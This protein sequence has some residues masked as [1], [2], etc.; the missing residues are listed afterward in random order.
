MKKKTK[1]EKAHPGL[2][3][4]RDAA[5]LDRCCKLAKLLMGFFDVSHLS[6]FWMLTDPSVG[7]FEMCVYFASKRRHSFHFPVTHV[8]V[9][10]RNL[11][12]EAADVF[13]FDEDDMGK[14]V[15][16]TPWSLSKLLITAGATELMTVQAL[17]HEDIFEQGTVSVSP[18]ADPVAVTA[19]APRGDKVKSPLDA[20]D[21]PAKQ[22]K[23]KAGGIRYE[24]PRPPAVDVDGGGPGGGC[25][26]DVD[27]FT[28]CS[29]EADDDGPDDGI[30]DIA[31]DLP[32][33][34]APAGPMPAAEPPPP[35]P[36]PPVP[37]QPVPP[38]PV[39][40]P[41]VPAP[42]VPPPAAPRP[43]RHAA[44]RG[45]QAEPWGPWVLAPIMKDGILQIG[46]GATCRMHRD[47]TDE[48]STTCKKQLLYGH[49]GRLPDYECKARI[50]MWLLEGLEIDP[51]LP[52]ARTKHV[53]EVKPRLLALLSDE[54]IEARCP[55]ADAM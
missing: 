44:A 47:F 33:G 48:G 28:D 29:E 35:V 11:D 38:P 54:E 27:G 53:R 17:S 49:L 37:A 4:F 19:R 36:P 31:I 15:F 45:S 22:N 2:C 30:E 20:L 46:W 10:L 18:A 52:D 41:P 55:P 9:L 14:P 26:G 42:P 21:Q 7:G 39:P 51:D 50:K 24:S 13:A 16:L 32:G 12:D 1:E 25:G 43:R 3:A 8:W 40:P 34:P 5:I 6:R 23:R